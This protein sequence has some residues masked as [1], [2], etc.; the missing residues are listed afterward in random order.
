MK[1]DGKRARKLLLTVL[2]VGVVSTVVGIG[3]F[4]AFSSTTSND[5]N[6]FAAGTVY[7]SDNDANAA[8][9]SVADR[10][11]NDS[12]QKCIAVTYGGSL[13]ADVHLYWTPSGSDTLSQYITLQVDK[14]TFSGGTPTFPSCTGTG[15]SIASSSNLFNANMN[16]FGTNY[17][18]GVSAYPGSQTQWNNGDTLYYRFTLTLQDTNSANGGQTAKTTGAHSF[19]WEAHQ[20]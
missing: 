1:S 15:I 16:T 20:Q 7:I 12:V 14:V 19:T 3:T 18:G 2:V 6:S 11:P 8:M 4:S 13:P 9:Y 17:A 10:K 5:N